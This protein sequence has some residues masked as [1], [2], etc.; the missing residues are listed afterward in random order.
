[1]RVFVLVICALSVSL[2]YAQPGGGGQFGGQGG[3]GGQGG[4]QQQRP[5]MREF[6]AAEVAGIFAYDVDEAI[7]KIKIKKNKDLELKVTRAI[8]KYNTKVSEVGLL[9]KDNFDTLNVYVNAMMK[10][11]RG[12]RGQQRG[13][14]QQSSYGND[15][16]RHRGGQDEENEKSR[17][18]VREKI[19]PVKRAIQKEERKLNDALQGLLNDKQYEKWLKYQ[20]KFKEEQNPKPENNQQRGGGQGRGGQGGPPGGGGGLRR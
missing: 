14:Q 10:S 7:K 12:S 2:T 4:Q 8:S 17:E 19:E 9:N 3:G 18:L 20:E 13:D 15:D 1:M 5:E 16:R 6:N 11:R